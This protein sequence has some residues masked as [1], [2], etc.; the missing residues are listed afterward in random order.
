MFRLLTILTV[1]S[2]CSAASLAKYI[3]PRIVGGTVADI[4]KHPHLV[5]FRV[6]SCE[7]CAYIHKCAAIIYSEKVLITN[8]QCLTDLDSKWRLMAVAGANSRSG[9]DG[10]QMPISNYTAHPEYNFWTIE[11]DIGLLFLEEALPLNGIDMKAI[12][13]AE[14]PPLDGQL[15]VVSGWGWDAEDGQATFWLHD[16]EVLIVDNVKCENAYGPGEVTEKMICAGV[17]KGGKDGCQEDT[18][19][20]L[21]VDNELVGM[22]SWG[23][24]C[25]RQGYP[26]VY[27]NVPFYK[28]WINKTINEMF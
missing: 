15:A 5:S 4:T 23:R 19:G 6:K 12:K 21:E 26:G 16:T 1:I 10:V 13:I 24:G 11:N 22:V 17:S 20:P 9:A 3:S 2:V 7:Q 25:G 18:G 8:A 27:T 28:D 14:K